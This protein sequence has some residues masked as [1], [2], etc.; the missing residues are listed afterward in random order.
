[1]LSF[2]TF[3]VLNFLFFSPFFLFFPGDLYFLLQSKNAKKKRE[4][5]TLKI[6]CNKLSTRPFSSDDLQLVC[7]IIGLCRV[8]QLICVAPI[9]LHTYMWKFRQGQDDPYWC[10]TDLT[11]TAVNSDSYQ[12]LDWE[13]EDNIDPDVT[14]PAPNQSPSN[15]PNISLL[16]LGN[17]DLVASG[18]TSEGGQIFLRLH[19]M[20]SLLW[21]MGDIAI[22]CG[23]WSASSIGT[24]TQ[25]MGRDKFLRPLLKI[26]LFVMFPFLALTVV[27]GIA[28]VY[29][30][31][32][33]NWG[34]PGTFTP[35]TA[36][37]ATGYYT[38]FCVVLVSQ[39]LEVF[40]WTSI[41]FGKSSAWIRRNNPLRLVHATGKDRST[42][43][44]VCMTGCFKF[45]NMLSCKRSDMKRSGELKDAAEALLAFFSDGVGITWTDL[46]ISIR[47]LAQIQRERKLERVQMALDASKDYAELAI[48][49]SLEEA[50]KK[51]PPTIPEHED[52]TST[53]ASNS[54]HC[55]NATT[56][57][58]GDLALSGNTNGT[59]TAAAED[60]DF[61]DDSIVFYPTG[62]SENS[63]DE[64]NDDTG[65]FSAR[66]FD[67]DVDGSFKQQ[68]LSRKSI[69]G[70]SSVAETTTTD[71]TT[72]EANADIEQPSPSLKT[73]APSTSDRS[74]PAKRAKGT[75]QRIQ[76][77]NVRAG[78]DKKASVAVLVRNEDS[79]GEF[80]TYKPVYRHLLQPGNPDDIRRVQNSIRYAKHSNVGSLLLASV[81]SCYG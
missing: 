39:S 28:M 1:M 20:L 55:T 35:G 56:L 46:Y 8:L 73:S 59:C 45:C 63:G 24:P 58:A 47:V 69:G 44:D 26:K 51:I 13:S 50:K 4:M 27:L 7:L 77:K 43:L 15:S 76:R 16:D 33:I 78:L 70:D 65:F 2:F 3:H 54:V 62:D 19:L 5:P 61:D 25:L 60:E 48:S 75:S 67:D 72:S 6:C 10:D 79:S 74:I 68:Q 53:S 38:L 14:V 49:R 37:E 9:W 41:A 23:I 11:E 80:E 57:L 32:T 17:E 12:I 40:L 22:L 81:V 42:S 29:M 30:N 21:V 34:C 31:R 18:K 64:I 36:F 52:S 71:N 66:D